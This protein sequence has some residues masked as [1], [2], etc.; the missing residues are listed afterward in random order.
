VAEGAF[1]DELSTKEAERLIDELAASGRPV[2]I[3]SGGEPLLRHDLFQLAERASKQ[4]L[5]VALA[6]N[7]TLIDEAVAKSI[8]DCGIRRVSISLDGGEAGAHDAFRRQEGAFDAAKRGIAA[9]RKRD[10][11]IQINVTVA[12]HNVDRLGD[13]VGLAKRLGAVALHLFL[14]VP[15]GCGLEI[16]QEQAITADEYEETLI[17]LYETER[18]ELTLQL[19][20][21]CAPHYFRVVRQR[22]V[23]EPGSCG[24]GAPLSPSVRRQAAVAGSLH[25]ATRGCL[26]GTGVCFIS[27]T[28]KV[29]GCGYLP[30]EAGDIRRQSFS[31]IWHHSPL[32]AELRDL[33]ALKGSCGACEF[34]RVCGGCRARAYGVSGD[35]LAEEPFCSY[36]PSGYRPSGVERRTRG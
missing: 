9:L 10:V 2:F 5:M 35:Y 12:K 11:P 28:G 30:V 6:S 34:K 1:P 14:L 16:A 32:F 27:H 23:V 15:V 7:G 19:K 21:T 17:W 4:G 26:A 13:M 22:Q 36:R 20:A 33:D 29:Y 25:A 24:S 3:L 31:D 8:K 18:E